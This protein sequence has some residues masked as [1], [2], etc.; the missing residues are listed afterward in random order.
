M[1]HNDVALAV[2]LALASGVLIQCVA[3]SVRVPAIILLLGA[4]VALGPAGLGVVRPR[5]LGEG[6]FV[7]VDF[8]VAVILFEGALNLDLKRLRRA[9]P[10]IRQLVIVGALVTLFGG[11]LAARLWLGW[12][13]TLAVLFGSSVVVTG[14]TVVGSLI[15]DL[16]LRPRL[17][18]ILEA[19][20]VLIDPIGAL[21]AVLVLQVTL[22]AD[23]FGVAAQARDLALRLVVG[24]TL[25]VAGGFVIA[26]L[27]RV[28][29][30]VH[31]L[32]N[33]LTLALVT[34]LFPREARIFARSCFWSLPA[35]SSLRV[36]WPGPWPRSWG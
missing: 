24:T 17:H 14:P 28:P 3:R 35:R 29:A 22:A 6:L 33:I 26:G 31:G 19:E 36:P 12:S 8:A 16:R 32:E 13:W 21:L 25:G 2:A 11:A 5:E 20:G 4:G 34:V 18:T 27:L 30:F 23:A 1:S 7:I 15:R 10:A 9:E